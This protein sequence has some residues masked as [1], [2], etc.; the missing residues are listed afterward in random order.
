MHKKPRKEPGEGRGSGSLH[1]KNTP[2]E[3]DV[4]PKAAGTLLG[5]TRIYPC[6]SR[7]LLGHG[8]LRLRLWDSAC[9]CC[10]PLLSTKWAWSFTFGVSKELPGN[11]FILPRGSWLGWE[12]GDTARPCWAAEPWGQQPRAVCVPAEGTRTLPLHHAPKRWGEIICCSG[13]ASESC[14]TSGCELR[15]LHGAWSKRRV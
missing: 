15:R 14:F 3:G 8:D 10:S 11:G 12:S 4:P 9:S 5:C 13:L 1:P 6:S 7:A 2:S